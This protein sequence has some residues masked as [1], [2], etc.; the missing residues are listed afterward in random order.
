MINLKAN[1]IVSF[2]NKNLL[3]HFAWYLEM[4]K[5]Y[6]IETFSTDRLVKKDYFYGK[7]M[8]KIAP[9][10]SPRPFLIVVNNPKQPLH[11]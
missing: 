8:Q 11:A 2:L 6:D 7:I 9:K 4:E 3:T 10:A 1:D 5:R